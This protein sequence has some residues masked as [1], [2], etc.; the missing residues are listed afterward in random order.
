V[1]S[2][3]SDRFESVSHRGERDTATVTLRPVTGAD[4]PFLYGLVKAT[5]KGYV[6]Q[7]W[8]WDEEWQRNYFWARFD[9]AQ[10]EGR[11]SEIIVREGEDIGVLT[12]EERADEVFLSQIYIL[13]QH[14]GQGIGT[15]LIRSVLER[16]AKLGLPVRLRVLRVNPA[17]RLYERLG[18]VVTDETDT[19]LYMQ[20]S[21]WKLP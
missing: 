7:T 9:P 1:S 17:R 16:G 6:D 2:P 20:A 3:E 13:P 10:R 15:A 21:P 12:V 11:R 4:G 8:G 5:M 14:Q 19:R 18:F